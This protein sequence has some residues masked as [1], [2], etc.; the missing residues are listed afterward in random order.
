AYLAQAGLSVLGGLIGGEG[1][2]ADILQVVGGAG[3]PLLFLKFGRTAEEQSDT[4]GAQMMARAG[5]DPLAL[6]SF[7]ETLESQSRG[8]PPEFLSSHPNYADRR[9]NIQRESGLLT[10]ADRD[11]VGGLSG[12]QARLADMRPAPSM[13]D[14]LGEEGRSSSS[15]EAERSPRGVADIDLERP[16]SRFVEFTQKNQYYRIDHPENWQ[17]YEARDGFGATIAPENGIVSTGSGR[18]EIL[19]GVLVNHYAPF[20]DGGDR[21]LDS[22]GFRNRDDFGSTPDSLQEATRDL[23]VQIMDGNPNLQPVSDS[24]R[25]R[26]VDERAALSTVLTGTS[27]VTGESERVTLLTREAGD[28]H[29]LYLLLIGPGDEYEDLE[30]TFERMVSSLEVNDRAVHPASE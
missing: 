11:P 13:E 7:F 8:A 5:Y 18:Q 10:T 28:G 6:V 3:V 25:R 17:V 19:G 16:S 26:E 4:V 27:P 22:M 14:L 1:A 21:S 9:E 15:Q 29:V 2:A 20:L 30:D 12:V 23:L 24:M